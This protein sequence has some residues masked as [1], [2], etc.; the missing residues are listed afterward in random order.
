M[1]ADLDSG[2]P[3]FGRDRCKFAFHHGTLHLAA[4]DSDRG[5]LRENNILQCFPLFFLA[6]HIQL[7]CWTVFLHIDRNIM[8]IPCTC[9]QQFSHTVTECLTGAVVDI[10][11]Q[12]PDRIFFVIFLGFQHHSP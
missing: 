8:N 10:A 3:V 1:T 12:L 2:I 11:F 7:I 4:T 6:D 5:C 9:L